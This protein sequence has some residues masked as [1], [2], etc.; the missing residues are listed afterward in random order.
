MIRK[1]KWNNH[2]VLGS[3]ELDF[4][5]PDGSIYNTI[6][7]AG[8]NQLGKEVPGFQLALFGKQVIHICGKSPDDLHTQV[9]AV[10]LHI[11]VGSHIVKMLGGGN[12][13]SILPGQICAVCLNQLNETMLSSNS[14]SKRLCQL[15]SNSA[16]AI[17]YSMVYF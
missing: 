8:E 6:V 4:T 12:L 14:L 2:D 17:P 5:K 9:K 15:I 1:I 3:L 16:A 10:F 13:G 11:P 7:L